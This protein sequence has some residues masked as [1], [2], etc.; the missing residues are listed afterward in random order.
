MSDDDDD[1]NNNNLIFGWTYRG[2]LKYRN[3]V[4][5]DNTFSAIIYFR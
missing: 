4:P 2:F 3:C 5:A 1:D